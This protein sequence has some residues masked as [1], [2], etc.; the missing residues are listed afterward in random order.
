MAAVGLAEQGDQRPTELSGGQQQ[1]VTI[2]RALTDT[3]SGIAPAS[4]VAF[5]LAQLVGAAIGAALTEVF[6]PR[7]GTH[8]EPLDLPAPVHLGDGA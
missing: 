3:F 2:A 1:R 5:I 6:Y 7:I 8:P 4:V